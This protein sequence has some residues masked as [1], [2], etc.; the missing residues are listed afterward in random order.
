MT[1]WE[2]TKFWARSVT[3][4]TG[5]L[6]SLLMTWNT[7]TGAEK[8]KEDRAQCCPWQY[9]RVQTVTRLVKMGRR[10]EEWIMA[11][12]DW[13]WWGRGKWREETC[14][15]EGME[16]GKWWTSGSLTDRRKDCCSEIKGTFELPLNAGFVRD[17]LDDDRCQDPEVL[18]THVV[19]AS[20]HRLDLPVI[21][22]QMDKKAEERTLTRE[23]R[24]VTL[25]TG[26]FETRALMKGKKLE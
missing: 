26:T 11:V 4:S 9:R 8:K 3:P 13:S 6:L 24:Q 19:L 22:Q 1:S 15:E 5:L 21:V 23:Q 7:V 16:E 17:W 25:V 14:D 12:S 18:L 2:M 20:D 10:E